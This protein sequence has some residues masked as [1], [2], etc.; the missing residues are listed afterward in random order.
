MLELLMTI[1]ATT[2]SGSAVMM[3]R[4]IIKKVDR[5][6]NRQRLFNYKLDTLVDC[7]SQQFGNGA[8]KN[9]YDKSLNQRM[10]EDNFIYKEI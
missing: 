6:N 8:F 5:G 4:H 1:A 2:L 7:T 3:L 9:S 10:R